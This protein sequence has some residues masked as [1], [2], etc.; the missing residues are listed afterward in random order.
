MAHWTTVKRILRYIKYTLH[1]SLRIIKLT[2]TILSAFPDVNWV[3]C[4]DERKST[5]GFAV[6]LGPNLVSWCAKKQPTVSRSSMEAEYKSMANAT[7]EI[8]WVQAL[9]R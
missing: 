6:F 3:G 7:A 2:S 9:L 8:M 1:T 5:E 4:S